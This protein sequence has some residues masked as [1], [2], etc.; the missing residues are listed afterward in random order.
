VASLRKRIRYVLGSSLFRQTGVYGLSHLAA[1]AIPF[2]LLPVLTRY[3]TP[4]DYGIV[5]MFMLATVLIVPFVEYSLNEAIKVRYVDPET[6]LGAFV[7]T[8]YVVVLIGALVCGVAVV[9]LREPLSRVT[10][11][12][13]EWIVLIVP[14]AAARTV[15]GS[16]T[17]LW[18]MQ[19]KALLYGIFQ[20]LQSAAI[21]G[22]ALIL[23]VAMERHW[24]GR[25]EA[26]LAAVGVS[27]L[28]AIYYLRR[29]GLLGNGYRRD[30]A[31]QLL[32][33]GVP[34]IPHTLSIFLIA[35]T[36]RIFVTNL[37][38]VSATGLLTVGFQLALIIELVA[39]SFNN[40]YLPWLFERLAAKED[41]VD[42]K[43]VRSTYLYF[44]GIC[45]V[46]IGVAFIMPPVAAL[47][48]DESYDG[49][50]SYV[51]WFAIAFAFA[52]MHR[53]LGNVIMFAGRTGWLSLVT[54][55]TAVLNI[56]LNFILI[57]YNGAIGAA[58]ATAAASAF[59]FV[60][61]WLTAARAHPLPWLGRD[62]ST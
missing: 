25:I 6:D 46:A 3:L 19:G 34:L 47:I 13:P 51:R 10:A 55:S 8:G 62:G 23:V 36:D 59:A 7:S 49:S 21:I 37:V 43:I 4:A 30:Y 57:H 39:V 26:E 38:D 42:R 33:F 5:S 18:R 16:V 60:L 50:G 56:P 35:Q 9:L 61:M 52:G 24:Q 22:A 2:L 14:L 53:V 20:N 27:A 45:V 31:R 28:F 17:V 58:Q 40:A 32:S 29:A 48:L 1:K 44:G 15:V 12:P 11:V 41:A 54:L